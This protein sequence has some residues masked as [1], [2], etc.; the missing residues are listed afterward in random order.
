M[1]NPPKHP[2]DVVYRQIQ[3]TN[4][5]IIEPE[6]TKTRVIDKVQTMLKRLWVGALIGS[7]CIQLIVLT[8]DNIA[9]RFIFG[10]LSSSVLVG[11]CLYQVKNNIER[12]LVSRIQRIASRTIEI[13][14]GDIHK[15]LRGKGNDEISELA[16]GIERMR[17]SIQIAME[18]NRR[19]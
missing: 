17:R 15:N 19:G 9:V 18:M 12:G 6:V 11:W 14:N 4:D 16:N 13:S 3:T 7:I 2:T 5:T 10:V 1:H 8:I